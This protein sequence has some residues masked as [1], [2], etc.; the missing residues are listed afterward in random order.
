MTINDDGERW[1]NANCKNIPQ[2]YERG[3]SVAKNDAGDA[4][5]F[6]SQL[7]VNF[8]LGFHIQYV[9]KMSHRDNK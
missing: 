7:A 4:N 5:S 6:D 1:Q 3:S 9:E 8:K 2:H